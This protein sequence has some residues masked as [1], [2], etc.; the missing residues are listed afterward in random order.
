MFWYLWSLV[1]GFFMGNGNIWFFSIFI[2]KYFITLG[3]LFF[4][5]QLMCFKCHLISNMFDLNIGNLVMNA[6]AISCG[7]HSGCCF[8]ISNKLF[9]NWKVHV[10]LFHLLWSSLF[11]LVG[12]FVMSSFFVSHMF[13]LWQSKETFVW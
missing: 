6:N 2:W 1:L 10:N 3:R 11:L 5:K 4:F 13:W 7:I 8:W 9:S 12:S